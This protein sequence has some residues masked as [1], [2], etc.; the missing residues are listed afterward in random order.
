MHL[1]DKKLNC[2]LAKMRGIKYNEALVMAM[3]N[4]MEVVVLGSGMYVPPKRPGAT[5]RNPSGYAVVLKDEILIFDFGFGNLRQM[6]KA[7]LDPTRITNIFITHL[8]LDHLGDLAAI[9]FAFHFDIKPKT[10]RLRIFGPKGF[11]AFFQ[12]MLKAYH[13]WTR[14]DGYSLQVEDIREGRTVDGGAWTLS[15]QAV[16]HSITANA[17]RLEYKGKSFCYTGDTAYD[18]RIASFAKNA[19]VFVLECTLPGPE[20]LYGHMTVPQSLRL[21]EQSGCRNA[22]LTHL[23]EEAE[24][25]LAKKKLSKSKKPKILVAQD[26]MRIAV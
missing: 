22:V 1:G 3:N 16:P 18:E 4:K 10:G 14:P 25:V 26:L 15:V 5:H 2:I 6:S 8:H 19:D 7:G 21:A 9:L 23:S 24:S 11:K 13:P 20:A 12:K 17:Y